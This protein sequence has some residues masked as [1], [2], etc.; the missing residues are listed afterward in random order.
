M[1]EPENPIT[2]DN[3]PPPWTQKQF[4][5]AKAFI[6]EADC[7]ATK[8]AKIAG[9]AE[10][11]AY[12]T[13]S[14]MLRKPEYLHVQEYIKKEIGEIV[15]QFDVSKEALIR[16]LAEIMHADITDLVEITESGRM[17]LKP[18][19]QMPQQYTRAIKQITDKSGN[20][21]EVSLQLHCPIAAIEKLAKLNKLFSDDDGGEGRA[22]NV[23]VYLPDNGRN[24]PIRQKQKQESEHE[25]D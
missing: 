13:G 1:S 11:S 25:N 17:R 23:H 15:E 21:D 5:F 14:R 7:N 22:P 18:I 9:Y 10:R 24:D 16:R 3:L 20:T 19:D 6:G 12:D 2:I 8:A 4:L